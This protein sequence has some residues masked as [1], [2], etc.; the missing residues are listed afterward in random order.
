MPLPIMGDPTGALAALQAQIQ[1]MQQVNAYQANVITPLQTENA[2][3]GAQG[4]LLASVQG[5]LGNVDAAEKG[6]LI[7]STKNQNQAEQKPFA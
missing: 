5:T 4:S 2:L 6:A 1:S 7:D 3:V